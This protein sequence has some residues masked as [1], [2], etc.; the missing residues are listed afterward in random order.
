MHVQ[1][2]FNN[3][4]VYSCAEYLV[5]DDVLS[6]NKDIFCSVHSDIIEN[7]IVLVID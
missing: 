4:H 1:S 5:E 3:I 6:L 2:I 7:Y